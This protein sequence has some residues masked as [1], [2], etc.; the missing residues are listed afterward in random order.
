VLNTDR[1]VVVT[2]ASV[3]DTDDGRTADATTN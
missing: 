2:G 1:P 3:T